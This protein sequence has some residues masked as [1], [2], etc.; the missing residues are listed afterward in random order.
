[1][2]AND[3]EGMGQ[4]VA[5]GKAFL[6]SAWDS[7][8][9]LD[10]SVWNNRTEVRILSGK[11]KGFKGNHRE[12]VADSVTAGGSES[13]ACLR[14][15]AANRRD[16]DRLAPFTTGSGAGPFF[17]TFWRCNRSRIF[18]TRGEFKLKFLRRDFANRT[19][20]TNRE[21][22]SDQRRRAGAD[23]FSESG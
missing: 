5:S 2:K 1:M 8:R 13:H 4:M 3:A 21:R 11:Y 7:V 19:A 20:R 18:F 22:D 17:R 16:S 23:Y 14:D 15:S 6:T 10:I 12:A 9:V